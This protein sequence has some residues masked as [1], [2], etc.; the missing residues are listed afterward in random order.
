MGLR[1]SRTGLTLRLECQLQSKSELT[2]SE[3]R[4]ESDDR[5]CQTRFRAASP[6]LAQGA[7]TQ[8]QLFRG[9]NQAKPCGV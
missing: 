3:A 6:L 5:A 2:Y 1:L 7:A 8:A 9:F 4:L